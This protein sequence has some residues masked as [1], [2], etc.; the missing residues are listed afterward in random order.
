M[1]TVV[2]DVMV[3]T[4][5][6]MQVLRSSQCFQARNSEEANEWIQMERK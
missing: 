5:R 4:H 2:P 1:L 6:F 3:E